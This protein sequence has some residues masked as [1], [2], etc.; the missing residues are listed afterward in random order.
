MGLRTLWNF[1]MLYY[2]AYSFSRLDN[3]QESIW[4]IQAIY[5]LVHF[6]GIFL[7]CALKDDIYYVTKNYYIALIFPLLIPFGFMEYYDKYYIMNNVA[8]CWLASLLMFNLAGIFR[9]YKIIW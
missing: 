1:V 5:I 2:V 9:K 4:Y 6:S 3:L 7:F 8:V